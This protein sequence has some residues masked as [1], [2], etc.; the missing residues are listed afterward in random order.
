MPGVLEPHI[1][2]RPQKV[3]GKCLASGDTEGPMIDTARQITA[4]G[5][6]YISVRWIEATA[7][8]LLGM[9]PKAEVDER[10]AD[11][12][13]RLADQAERLH[14]LQRFEDAAAEYEDARL[15]V[16]KTVPKEEN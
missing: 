2:D 8:R 11:L 14:A 15:G 9:V 7:T 16:L 12:E 1:V 5:Q 10:F 13:R 4:R 3:P 6:V